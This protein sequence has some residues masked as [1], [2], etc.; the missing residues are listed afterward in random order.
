MAVIKMMP[1]IKGGST[2]TIEYACNG[3]NSN[4]INHLK[5]SPGTEATIAYA[6]NDAKAAFVSG[7]NCSPETAAEQFITTR[8]LWN[9]DTGAKC[10]H[11]IQSFMPG[12]VSPEKAHKIAREL[13]AQVAPGYEVVIGTH[14]DKAHIH[15]HI[16]I[17]SVNKDFGYKYES[18]KRQ[19]QFIKDESD[20]L[21]RRYKLSVIEKDGRRPKTTQAEIHMREKG[22][23]PWKDELRENIQDALNHCESQKEFTKYL[24]EKYGIQVKWQNVNISFLHPDKQKYVRGDTLGD[25]FKKENIVQSLSLRKDAATDQITPDETFN[26]ANTENRTPKHKTEPEKYALACKENDFTPDTENPVVIGP[27]VVDIDDL[28]NIRKT[29]LRVFLE[30]RGYEL[31]RIDERAYAVKGL[32]GIY[33]KDNIRKWE[34][35]LFHR[36]GNAIDFLIQ[37]ERMSYEEA[38]NTLRGMDD[39]VKFNLPD[40]STSSDR[41]IDYLVNQS[42]V[43]ET[44]INELADKG[45]IYE[46]KDSG[47]IVFLSHDDSGNVHGGYELYASRKYSGGNYCAKTNFEYDFH[48]KG[49]IGILYVYADPLEVLK[50][51]SVQREFDVDDRQHKLFT[52]HSEAVIKYINTHNISKVVTIDKDNNI[53]RE[54]DAKNEINLLT[55]LM[56]AKRY[57]LEKYLDDNKYGIE[58]SNIYYNVEGFEGLKVNYVDVNYLDKD[59][60][61][62]FR[63]KLLNN[64]YDENRDKEGSTIKFLTD[65]EG[66]TY[67][68]AVEKLSGIKTIYNYQAPEKAVDNNFMNQYL[69]RAGLGQNYINT[70]VKSGL[71]YQDRENSLIFNLL[72]EKGQVRGGYKY[73]FSHDIGS[74]EFIKGSNISTCFSIKGDSDRVI[75]FKDPIKLLQYYSSAAYNRE[76]LILSF[77]DSSLNR[78]LEANNG[79]ER[80]VFYNDNPMKKREISVEQEKLLYSAY[81]QAKDSSLYGYLIQHGYKLSLHDGKY[82]IE[83]NEDLYI[84]NDRWYSEKY[85]VIGGSALDFVMKYE[86]YNFREAAAIISNNRE[87]YPLTPP[88]KVSNSDK[89]YKYLVIDVGLDKDY[90]KSLISKG[91]VYE[92]NENKVVF[93]SIDKRNLYRSAYVQDM[94]FTRKYGKSVEGSNYNYSFELAGN[95]DRVMV[96]RDHVQLLKYTAEENRLNKQNRTNYIDHKVFALNEKVVERYTKEHPKVTEISY[97]EPEKHVSLDR[98]FSNFISISNNLMRLFVGNNSKQEARARAVEFGKKKRSEIDKD[99]LQRYLE[100]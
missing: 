68:E 86:G 9:K 85:N 59:G 92:T 31:E 27:K 54:L 84:K 77:G 8:K 30:N 53:V 13:A 74:G 97:V 39:L 21:C 33:I 70:L 66:Y 73:D 50:Q 99:I 43:S 55:A 60:K 37:F 81:K 90:A 44:L 34:S 19:L 5:A 22:I 18:N 7:I 61:E 23:K 83:G 4:C 45:L 2:R 87:A 46:E 65:Y 3:K 20:A 11:M 35:S 52:K 79:I 40:V 75:V 14:I 71:I 38:V 15:N 80:I 57:R 78:Y 88:P 1:P 29:D 69:L 51:E 89:L 6:L 26:K 93:A 16:V 47:N 42:G 94:T 41:M 76:H 10:Y 67:W 98:T 36:Q 49:N 32:T 58:K 64:W 62:V 48:I 12:E 17:N 82:M 63:R 95:T 72:D 100:S 24:N 28:K 91:L 25:H 56:A 96:F